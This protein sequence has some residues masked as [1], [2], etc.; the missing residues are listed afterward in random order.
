MSNENLFMIHDYA[1]NVKC[2]FHYNNI[3]KKHPTPSLP[4][5]PVNV[6]PLLLQAINL[7]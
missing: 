1:I 5:P 3:H 6:S 7:K 4:S 2:I